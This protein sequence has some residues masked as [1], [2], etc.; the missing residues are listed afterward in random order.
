MT[1]KYRIAVLFVALILTLGTAASWGQLPTGNDISDVN[2]NTGGGF[3]ALF[4]VQYSS[5]Q[6]N[7]GYGAYALHDT[8][9][10]GANTAMGYH[11]LSYNTSGSDNTATGSDA[12]LSNQYGSFN[13]ANGY[14]ALRN[15]IGASYNTAIGA[16]ALASNQSGARHT[17]VGYLAL[18]QNTVG[19]DNTALGYQAL[20]SNTGGTGNLALGWNAGYYATGSNNIYLANYGLAGESNTMRLGAQTSSAGSPTQRTFIAGIAAVPVTGSQ[21]LI[22]SNG[23]LGVLASSARYKRDIQDMGE[24][25]EGLLKLRPV[26]FRYKQDPEAALQYGLIAEEVA[27]VYPELVVRGANGEVESIQYH[28]IISM[29]LNEVQH[30]QKA[31]NAQSQQITTQSQQIA[32]LKAQN[33]EQHSHNAA[34]ETRLE[35]LEKQAAPTGMLAATCKKRF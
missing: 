9:S 14:M 17:A 32:E 8:L 11:A 23:Q 18:W 34:L 13:T 22:N 35:R 27:K 15:N 16:Q 25:T 19:H 33:E 4:N 20:Y 1:G 21:V 28:Q 3:V 31:L 12:L 29:L 7:T 10:G 26:T 24:R 5:G 2:G 6:H 30:Q